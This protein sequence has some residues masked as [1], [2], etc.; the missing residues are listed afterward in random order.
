MDDRA[1][2]GEAVIAVRER[3][4]LAERARRPEIGVLVAR[5]HRPHIELD[6]L[7]AREGEHLADERRQR[8]TIENHGRSLPLRAHCLSWEMRR[9]AAT[10]ARTKAATIFAI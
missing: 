4:H 5:A 6:P 2:I 3:R 8:G 7:F 10:A 1:R 9:C